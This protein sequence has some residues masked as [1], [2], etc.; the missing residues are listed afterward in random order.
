[1]DD[2]SDI[3]GDARVALVTAGYSPRDARVAVEDARSQV[4]D[5]ATLE[6][7]IY[8]ALRCCIVTVRHDVRA[9]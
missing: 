1:V 6:Q 8:A 3:D 5:H 7:V 2:A 9:R 4:G